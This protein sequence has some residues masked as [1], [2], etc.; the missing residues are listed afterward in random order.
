MTL[1]IG[2]YAFD[3]V[4]VLDLAGPY[5]VFTTAARVYARDILAL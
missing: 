5:G 2:L 3:G 1:R 4:E